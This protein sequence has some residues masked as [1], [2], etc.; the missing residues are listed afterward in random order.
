MKAKSQAGAGYRS[1]I[2]SD[3]VDCLRRESPRSRPLADGGETQ[4]NP[5]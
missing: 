1:P 5:T 2:A 4:S 3:V